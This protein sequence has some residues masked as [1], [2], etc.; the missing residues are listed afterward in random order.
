MVAQAKE[1]MWHSRLCRPN[2]GIGKEILLCRRYPE[3]ESLAQ[4][5]KQSK[6]CQCLDFGKEQY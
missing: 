1:D 2:V 4:D 5:S 3:E 6:K